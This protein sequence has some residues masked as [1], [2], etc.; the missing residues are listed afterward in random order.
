MCMRVLPVHTYVRCMYAWCQGRW[1]VGS[2]CPETRI[3]G[4]CGPPCVCRE[5]SLGPL[6]EQQVTCLLLTLLPYT[7]CDYWRRH[8]KFSAT[9]S[10][11]EVSASAVHSSDES[12]V[13][14]QQNMLGSLYNCKLAGGA[15][16]FVH[17]YTVLLTKVLSSS[18]VGWLVLQY[19][20]TG[21]TCELSTE[22]PLECQLF[23]QCCGT[24]Q[25]ESGWCFQWPWHADNW[26][27]VCTKG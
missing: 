22:L 14:G 18:L 5:R 24:S 9:L 4:G 23:S 27:A 10:R 11:P 25:F 2:R 6:Q 13:W 26:I 19:L 8:V 20:R 15:C 17:W 21:S 3:P 7:V 1:K 16:L 12:G